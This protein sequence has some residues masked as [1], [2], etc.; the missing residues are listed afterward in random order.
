M[1]EQAVVL[2][3]LKVGRVLAV[4]FGFSR[5]AI[6][7]KEKVL[8][9]GVIGQPTEPKDLVFAF[10]NLVLKL[11]VVG[12]SHLQLDVNLGKLPDHPINFRLALGCGLGVAAMAVVL[13]LAGQGPWMAADAAASKG[14]KAVRDQATALRRR[15]L[16]LPVV[17]RYLDLKHERG[18]LD[19]SDQMALAARLAQVAAANPM[20][21][22]EKNAR[23]MLGSLFAV[24]SL[25]AFAR[26]AATVA[27]VPAL[28]EAKALLPWLPNLAWLGAAIM[29]TLVV[30]TARR[31]AL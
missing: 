15:A 4:E 27:G 1:H 29:L 26:I 17:R 10:A 22:V 5:R 21:D 13:S 7:Q 12:R 28:P 9:V 11:V 14:L 8:C 19:F 18:V 31:R 20:G 30:G 25:A 16:V 24:L 3:V 23:A 6:Q 2:G